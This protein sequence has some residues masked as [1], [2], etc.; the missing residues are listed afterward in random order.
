MTLILFGTHAVMK[1]RLHFVLLL[2]FM[3]YGTVDR[4]APAV[5]AVVAPAP[6]DAVPENVVRDYAAELPRIPATEPADAIS[7]FHV[8]PGFRL[9]LVASEPL[10]QSPVACEWDENGRLYVCEMRGYSEQRDDGLSRISLLEDTDGDGCYDRSTVFADG[11]LWPTAIFPYDGGLFVADAPDI[12]FMRDDDGDG[13]ADTKTLVLTGFGTS[14]VQGLV[15]SFRWGL[16]NR[17]HLATSSCGGEIRRAA[18]PHDTQPVLIRGRDLAIDPRSGAFTLTS[19]ASQHGMSFDDWGRKFVSHNSNHIQQVMYE[20]R[21]VARNPFLAAPSPRAMIAADGPQAEVYR[22]SPVEPWRELRTRM[23]VTGAARGVVEGGGR[24]AGYFTGATGVTIYRGDA[25]PAAWHGIAVVGDAGGNLVHRKRLEG[26]GIELVARRIDAES[27]FVSSSDIWS[28][29]VQFANAP[30]GTLHMIDTYR[31]VIEHPQ[32]IPPEIKQHLDL[33]SGRERGRIYRIAP[34]DFR[35]RPAPRLGEASTVELVAFLEHP[36]GWQ[37]ETASRLLFI[38]QDMD[39]IPLLQELVRQSSFPLARLHALCGL[40]GLDGLDRPIVLEALRDPC[41]GVRRHAVRLAEAF[42]GVPEVVESVAAMAEDPDIEVRYQVA[43]SLGE[44]ATMP[45]TVLP[46][47]RE[48]LVRIGC[49]DAHDRWIRVAIQSSAVDDATDLLAG[50]LAGASER[51][52]TPEASPLIEAL[53]AQVATQDREEDVRRLVALLEPDSGIE[54]GIAIAFARGLTVG[55]AR[56]GSTLARL[57]DEGSLAWLDDLVVELVERAAETAADPQAS[58]AARVAAIEGL[59]MGY[60]P[61][62]RPTLEPLLDSREPLAIQA[63]AVALI[64]GFP[65]PQAIEVLIDAWPSLAP[66]VKEA[67]LEPLSTRPDRA[68][69]LLAAI[70]AGHIPAADIPEARFRLL[71]ASKH[72]DVS[73]GATKMLARVGS[74]HRQDVLALYHDCLALDGDVERGRMVFRTACASCHRVEGTG[75]ALGPNLASM[76]TRGPEAILVNVLDPNREVNPLYMNYVCITQDGR[77]VTGMLA[78]ETST[79]VTLRRAEGVEDTVLR[80]DIEEL[81]SLGQ[82]MMPEGLE[83]QVDPQGMADLIAYL[84]WAP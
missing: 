23:R 66:R 34:A 15:N 13:R 63:A 74:A 47:V 36:N 55:L 61:T 30:D 21:Y 78:S 18:D 42:F 77:T 12:F 24:A 76:K 35:S 28:R 37:R 5:D 57:R 56:Q 53:A 64:G 65:D 51:R 73:T 84:M 27:E 10:V 67:A 22:T 25:W 46:S 6:R 44:R 69:A 48:S 8:A 17:L 83:K 43:F 49:R 60:F 33:T 45:A 52:L 20:D 16:D 14:N 54:P 31:E 4:P 1:P 50:M 32:S 3:A 68:L 71:A 82:S 7:T 38:R 2:V 75:H 81:R 19:G 59:G 9:E 80:S 62:V 58:I 11:L 72:P 40:D 70:E 41:S 26:P 39:S 29:P 79:S